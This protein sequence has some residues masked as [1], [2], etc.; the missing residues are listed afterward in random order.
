MSPILLYLT[1]SSSLLLA[2]QKHLKPSFCLTW[3]IFFTWLPRHHTCLACFIVFWPF[4]M[5]PSLH[6]QSLNI[7]RLQDSVVGPSHFSP[8]LFTEWWCH[9]SNFKDLQYVDDSQIYNSIIDLSPLNPD[10]YFIS[11]STSHSTFL[12][13]FDRHHKLNAPESNSRL[14]QP[15]IHSPSVFCFLTR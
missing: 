4:L 11:L 2:N 6:L 10:P 3:N 8:T 5:N 7:L 14:S 12:C 1:A 13:N 9:I 15:P